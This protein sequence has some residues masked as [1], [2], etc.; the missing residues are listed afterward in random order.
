MTCIYVCTPKQFRPIY[1]HVTS[2]YACTPKQFRPIYMHATS[3]YTCTPTVV[4]S[5]HDSKQHKHPQLSVLQVLPITHNQSMQKIHDTSKTPCESLF[6]LIQLISIIAH[7][8][9]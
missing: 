7:N 2:I 8:S 3:I 9:K 4:A 6:K 1:M 5:K